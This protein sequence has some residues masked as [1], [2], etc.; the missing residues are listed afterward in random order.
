TSPHY[1]GVRLVVTDYRYSQT[2]AE[3]AWNA[4]HFDAV[5]GGNQSIYKQLNPTIKRYGYAIDYGVTQPG[6][7][8]DGL[9]SAFYND[10]VTWY[11]AHTQYRLENSF[12][13]DAALC[14]TG[15]PTASCRVSYG[16]WE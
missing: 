14:P 7:D 10:M 4:A 11:A 3:Y 8:K 5:L 13:H 6:H 1:P 16:A 15:T 12:L 2:S 9:G